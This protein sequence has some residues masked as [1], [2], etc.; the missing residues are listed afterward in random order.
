MITTTY[1][2]ACLYIYNLARGVIVHAIQSR[3]TAGISLH[4]VY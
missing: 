2:E 3:Y 4:V 1:D